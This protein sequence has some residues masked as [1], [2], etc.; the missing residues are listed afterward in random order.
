M[1]PRIEQII[2]FLTAPPAENPPQLSVAERRANWDWMSGVMNE[3]APDCPFEADRVLRDDSRGRLAVD[4]YRPDGPGPHPTVLYL[5]G[6]GWLMGSPTTHRKLTLRFAE[7]GF[8]CI[9]VDYALAPE[10][11]FPAGLDGCLDAARWAVAHVAELG[12][13]LDRMAIAGDSAGGNLAAAVLAAQLAEGATPFKAA[14]LIYGVFDFTAF[15]AGDPRRAASLKRTAE[16]YL[17][18]A[19]DDLLTDPRVSPVYSPHLHQFPP[20]QLLVGT[21]DF[22]LEQSRSFDAALRRAGAT[23]DLRIYEDMPHAFLQ[24]E[25]LPACGQAQN[26]MWSFLRQ[27]LGARQPSPA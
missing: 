5:H 2:G 26:D 22:L 24:I 21:K 9:S 27:H 6:G 23:A 18:T 3:N 13:D 25:D 8:L 7:A 16:D 10:H 1:D 17:G 11:Q 14:L 12:G 19:G 4:I 15:A 20:S